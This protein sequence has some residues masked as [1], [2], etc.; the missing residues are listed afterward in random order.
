MRYFFCFLLVIMGC[1]ALEPDYFELGGGMTQGGIRPARNSRYDTT[2]ESIGFTFGWNLGTQAKAFRNLAD[3]DVSRAGELTF[4]DNSQDSSIIINNQK[5]D[6][7]EEP[8]PDVL[9]P[10]HLAPKRTREESYAFIL[11]AGGILVLA[12]AL[13]LLRKSGLSIP[14]LSNR[15]KE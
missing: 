7:E 9:L 6:E 12:G 5:K 13:S 11:W 4:R 3:I 8:T 15:E 1:A 2:T 10:E 14:F